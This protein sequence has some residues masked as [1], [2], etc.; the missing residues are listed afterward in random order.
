MA[1]SGQIPDHDGFLVSAPACEV[2]LP[3]AEDCMVVDEETEKDKKDLKGKGK[4]IEKGKGRAKDQSI[5]HEIV[6]D[7]MNDITNSKQFFFY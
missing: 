7:Q 2:Q 5:D 1:E 4:A 6:G 3:E